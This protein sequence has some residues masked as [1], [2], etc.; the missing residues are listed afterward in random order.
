MINFDDF[1]NENIKKHNLN[2][3]QIP[4]H[5]FRIFLIGDFGSGKRKFII[6]FNKSANN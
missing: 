1:T 2:W 3:S 6:Q 4:D 5:P